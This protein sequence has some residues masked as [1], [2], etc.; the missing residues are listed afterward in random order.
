MTIEVDNAAR[1]GWAATTLDTF[2]HLTGQ[3][4]YDFNEPDNLLEIAGDLLCDLMHLCQETG[5]SPDQLIERARLHFEDELAE[6]GQVP[7]S[8]VSAKLT[9]R[10]LNNTIAREGAD[11]CY[12][13]CKYWENDRCIDCGS[14]IDE[15]TI[16][17]RQGD[18]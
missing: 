10:N 8:T 16:E 11:F 18:E 14:H 7:V 12:C 5:V 15:V 6:E 13:G 9:P 1:A 3:R 4:P 2:T 17:V